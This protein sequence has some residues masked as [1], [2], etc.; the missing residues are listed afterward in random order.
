MGLVLA[1]PC[2]GSEAQLLQ[3]SILFFVECVPRGTTMIIPYKSYK[4]FYGCF[5]L[6]AS[7]WWSEL[8][9]FMLEVK[10]APSARRQPPGR[11]PTGRPPACARWVRGP[12]GPQNCF[13][14]VGG[15][16]DLPSVR[17]PS[18]RRRAHRPQGPQLHLFGEDPRT[19]PYPLWP[20]NYGQYFSSETFIH[21]P[22][23]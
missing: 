17:P 8:V 11:R 19:L 20:P 5:R 6:I 7:A 14:Y 12:H 15:Q 9:A 21:K 4:L 23:Y 16:I 1:S 22:I 13:F 3:V 10:V 18:A 2:L